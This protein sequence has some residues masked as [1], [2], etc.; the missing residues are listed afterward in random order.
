MITM[1]S[2][3]KLDSRL[4]MIIAI[5]RVGITNRA[6]L[7]TLLVFDTCE[8][9]P[10][11]WYSFVPQSVIHWT[12]RRPPLSPV[13]DQCHISY[14]PWSR[15]KRQS[16][17]HGAVIM[18]HSATTLDGILWK[19]FIFR[20]LRSKFCVEPTCRRSPLSPLNLLGVIPKVVAIFCETWEGCTELAAYQNSTACYSFIL[21]PLCPLTDMLVQSPSK[22]TTRMLGLGWLTLSHVV[23]FEGTS[24]LLDL[25]IVLASSSFREDV[26]LRFD[27]GR[28]GDGSSMS[29]HKWPLGRNVREVSPRSIVESS[30]A[31]S[32]TFPSIK[33]LTRGDT[34]KDRPWITCC[35]AHT[36]PFDLYIS[37]QAM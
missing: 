29:F 36:L 6:Q 8:Q 1:S 17:N 34:V 3:W 24:T 14:R 37:L 5:Q 20:C 13:K 10:T 2:F 28:D 23:T 27:S 12:K 21:S 35:K 31:S 7:K 9:S 22:D 16:S 4:T 30:L 11:S 15:D 25:C 18:C 19:S 26:L 32:L 33:W